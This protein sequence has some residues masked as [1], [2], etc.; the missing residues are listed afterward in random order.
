MWWNMHWQ[1]DE[2]SMGISEHL[3]NTLDLKKALFYAVGAE[4]WNIDQYE[5]D[6]RRYLVFDYDS[7]GEYSSPETIVAIETSTP[8]TATTNL[9]L[10]GDFLSERLGDWLLIRQPRIQVTS[11]R[12]QQFV[13]DCANI[14]EYAR[15]GNFPDSLV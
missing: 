15:E 14:I 4:V 7:H 3:P 9:S 2:L 11:N 10:A 8:V 13:E 1:P 5:H 6:G 12:R